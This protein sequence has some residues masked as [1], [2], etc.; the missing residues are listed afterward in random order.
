MSKD[1]GKADLSM[2]N[3]HFGYNNPQFGYIHQ[4]PADH[5]CISILN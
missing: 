2:N 1:I 3:F 4:I 5:L